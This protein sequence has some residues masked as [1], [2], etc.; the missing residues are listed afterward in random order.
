MS[1]RRLMV[2]DDP[3]SVTA[4]L[5]E[6]VAVV[7]AGGIV[8]YPTETFYGLA[9]DP[10]NPGAVARLF[11][12]KGRASEKAF[13]LVA[14]SVEQIEAQVGDLPPLGHRLAAAFWPGPLTL[15]ISAASTLPSIVTG[16][17]GT[18]AVRIPGLAL[19][20]EFALNAQR[21]LTSTSANRA[22]QPPASTVGAVLVELDE[23]VDAVIDAGPSRGGQPTTIIDV[24][25]EPPVLIRAG[26]VP[27]ERVLESLR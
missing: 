15:V 13:P 6:A 20:R 4:S 25:R 16:G 27:W 3:A 22:G 10:L 11:D 21:P 26:A 17:S 18:V 1:A 24:T 7:L 19:A 8:A 23:M 14:A 12:V 9:V 2:T 5:A